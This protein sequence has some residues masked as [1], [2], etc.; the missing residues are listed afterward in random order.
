MSERRTLTKIDTA[1]SVPFFFLSLKWGRVPVRQKW[2]WKLPSRRCPV[3]IF[4]YCFSMYL[5]VY[6]CLFSLLETMNSFSPHISGEFFSN[7]VCISN[8]NLNLSQ[9]HVDRIFWS[10]RSY[11][12]VL[13]KKNSGILK[14][15]WYASCKYNYDLN[16]EHLFLHLY[17]H[18]LSK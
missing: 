5:L 14:G 18:F 13:E 1:H 16:S 17:L 10:F 15:M 4:L 6:S 9:E 2:A 8:L 7:I 3:L 12:K 11:K